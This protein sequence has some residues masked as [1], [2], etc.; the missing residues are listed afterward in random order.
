MSMA[1]LTKAR[2][3]KAQLYEAELL[4]SRMISATTQIDK[5]A[6]ATI[7]RAMVLAVLTVH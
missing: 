6:E 1:S 7:I 4:R 2:I 5:R 3:D